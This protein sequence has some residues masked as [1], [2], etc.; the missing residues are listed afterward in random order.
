MGYTSV[1]SIIFHFCEKKLQKWGS[2]IFEV[3]FSQ[4]WK[5]IDFTL[6]YHILSNFPKISILHYNTRF[7]W[8]FIKKSKVATLGFFQKKAK[9]RVLSASRWCQNTHLGE[10]ISRDILPP[11]RQNVKMSKCQNT[12]IGE[13]IFRD[14][15]PPPRQNVKMLKYSYWGGHI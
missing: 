14:I 7:F 12:H 9:N 13:V 10:V 5:N 15:L 8:N 4:K 11:P 2:P 3:F 6:V 1:K